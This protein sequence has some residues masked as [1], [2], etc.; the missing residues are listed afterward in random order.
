MTGQ[1][2]AEICDRTAKLFWGT[3]LKKGLDCPGKAGPKGTAW[4]ERRRARS[5]SPL[6]KHV[7]TAQVTKVL[8]RPGPS[9]VSRRM[10]RNPDL[11]Q[12]KGVEK[13]KRIIQI[14]KS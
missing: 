8:F 10:R 2:R 6:S 7:A 13:K 3:S 11:S 4:S 9:E 12:E 14:Q 5:P 1:P